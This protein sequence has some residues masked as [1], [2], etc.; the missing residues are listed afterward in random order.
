MF[1]GYKSNMQ[2]WGL[3]VLLISKSTGLKIE[4][5]LTD[6]DLKSGLLHSQRALAEITE[7]IRT[8]Q[9]IHK[10]IVNL[11]NTD[12]FGTKLSEDSELIFGN[13]IALLGG[14]Y[15]LSMSGHQLAVL[16]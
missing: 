12:E 6:W 9:L 1:N 13:K 7:M 8:S 3:I 16:K 5:E 11:Q 14:D 10:G 15:L 2:A 4:P